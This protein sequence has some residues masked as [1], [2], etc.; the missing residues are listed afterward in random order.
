MSSSAPLI[1][2]IVPVYNCER[3]MCDCLESILS[4]HYDNIEVIVVDDGST[5]SS[6]EI[7][8]RYSNRDERIMVVQ[9][10]N[11]GPSAAR[12]RGLDLAHG[13]YVA[14]VDADDILDPDCLEVLYVLCMDSGAEMSA[15][16]MTR[17][18][19]RLGIRNDGYMTLDSVGYVTDV[20]YQRVSDNSVSA[21]LF[22]RD[23]WHGIRFRDMRYEDLEVFPRV[24][25][26][27]RTVAVTTS[28]LYFYRPNE[29]SFV[30][31]YSESR[32]D[33]FKALE[34][35]QD[36]LRLHP[37]SHQMSPALTSRRLS[38]SFNVF[39]IT[40]GHPEHTHYN[41]RAWNNIVSTRGACLMDGSVR[42]KLKLGII[43]SY[44]GKT[45]TILLNRL[46][47]VSS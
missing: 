34:L 43:C 17:R 10:G 16:G 5:D 2:V 20:L 8:R 39:L 30:S 35:L 1:S 21:K 23:L 47:K 44:M 12:N 25:L 11:A 26:N 37:R 41:T 45:P 27:A 31:N 28:P 38:A 7:A 4:Q 29:D 42:T 24:C 40:H 46:F 33:V 22:H 36:Y 19:D 18:F 9:Q 14:F 15:C 3:Y 32:L 13:E 6:L